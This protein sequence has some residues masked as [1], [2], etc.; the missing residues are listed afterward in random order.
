MDTL[1]KAVATSV[2]QFSCIAH[3]LAAAPNVAGHGIVEGAFEKVYARLCLSE[4]FDN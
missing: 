3:V 4:F 1:R 2:S